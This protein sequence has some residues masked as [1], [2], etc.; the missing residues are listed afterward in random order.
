MKPPFFQIGIILLFSIILLVPPQAFSEKIKDPEAEKLILKEKFKE[1]KTKAEEVD[2][3]SVII[4]LST[5]FKPEGKLDSFT[6][7][8]QREKIKLD[9]KLLLDYLEPYDI[10]EFHKFQYIPAIEMKVDRNS[11]DRLESSPLVASITENVLYRALLDQSV[12][13]I[14]TPNVWDSGFTG[15]DQA[16][17]ILDT[18]VN[19]AHP[20]FAGKVITEACFSNNVGSGG[21]TST[22]VCPGGGD[23]AFGLGAGIN[24]GLNIFGCDHGTHVAG[25]A[26]GDDAMYSGVA[27]D[28]DLVAIQIFSRFT[29]P[30]CDSFNP[31]LPSPC[32]LA[33]TSDLIRGLEHVLSLHNLGVVISS[34]NLSIGGGQFFNEAT[35]DAANLAIKLAIDNLRSVGIAT[36]VASGN[37]GFTDSMGAPACISSA[38]SVGS[39]TVPPPPEQVSIFNPQTGSGT[40]VASFL[41]VHAPGSSIT[42][43][44]AAVISGPQKTI[45]KSGTSMATPHVAGAWALLKSAVPGATVDDVL[46]SLTNT[47]VPVPDTRLGGTEVIPRIQVDDALTDLVPPSAVPWFDTNWQFRKQITIN[48]AQVASALTDFP[49]LFSVTDTDLSVAQADGDDILFTAGDGVTPLSH[50]IESWNDAT[51]KLAAWVKV[52]SL[53]STTNTDIYIYYGYGTA[54]NQQDPNGGTWRDEYQAVYHMQDELNINDSTAN[55]NDA[56][57]GG[58]TNTAGK[59]DDAQS[60]VTGD[61]ITVDQDSTLD[62]PFMNGGTFSAWIFPQSAGEANQ[63]RIWVKSATNIKLHVPSADSSQL[64]LIQNFDTTNGIWRTANKDISFDQ[65]NHIAI[66]YNS[67]SSSND[68]IMYVDGV[69]KTI[70]EN[71]SP[72]GTAQAEVTSLKI[73]N[74]GSLARTFDGNIDEFRTYDGMLSSNWIKTEY[75]NQ[76][77]PGSFYMIGVQEMSPPSA[78][79][80]FDTNWQLRKQITINSAQVASALTDFTVLISVTDSDLSVAQAD[81][82]DILFTAG[83]G[84]TKLSHEIESWNDTPGK[85]VAWVK[86]PSLSSVTNTDIYIYYGNGAATNQQDT[87]GGTWRAEYKTVYH[88]HDDFLDSTANNNDATNSG[89]TDTA[90]KIE[91]AQSFGIGDV[92]TVDQD[93]TLDHP[94]MNGGTFSAWIFPQSA[95]EANQ[96]RIWV[97]AATNIKLHI[98]SAD[99]SQLRLIQNFDTTDGIWRTATRDISFDQWNHIAIVYNSD[100]SSNDPIM[101]VDGVPK[102]IRE[103]LSPV[104]TAQVEVTSLKIGNVGSLVRTFDGNIDEFR[105]YDGMLSS[106]WIKTE[107][108][109]QND[110]GSFYMIGVQ[111]TE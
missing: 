38:V 80:W 68:P 42:S 62:H 81:G 3:I 16:V 39:T 82:D 98:P 17:A 54:T 90:G 9:Q 101:Y 76:N 70:I 21:Q 69:P 37:D 105:M 12:L 51:G 106:N 31:P 107:Y 35:C 13:H 63:G 65:W 93:P 48:S 88:L 87:N 15:E 47:G 29:D 36:V 72:V 97:K 25:I 104:G 44:N 77:D 110:P 86:V 100:S 67:D 20:F 71:L 49:V 28:A 8:G 57:N 96:G 41:D 79:P 75:N 32:S 27:K 40:N 30:L 60:F 4:G 102:T 1:L 66:V 78:V 55:N 109:N 56:T 64:R 92:I 84:V 89:S 52:P 22:S 2:S 6:G 45:V 24:C 33:W 99:S 95:G 5:S 108:N 19:T 46:N 18:G 34:V 7:F 94:F 26:L 50:E 59:I 83:D 73:G 85:L 61:V 91:D 111:E 58:S 14:G 53:S 10:S 23:S 74:V 43:A 11:L 103:S